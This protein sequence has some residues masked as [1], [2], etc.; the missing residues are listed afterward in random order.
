M[1]MPGVATGPLL[2]GNLCLVT[3][4]IGTSDMPDLSGAI[5]LLEEIDEPP[6]KVD[7]MLT[8]LRRA[9][10]LDGSPASP[11]GSSPVAPTAGPSTSPM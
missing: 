4:S 1:R 5:L 8:H 10:C 6:Y 7:R 2:G 3:S 9:G 11:S